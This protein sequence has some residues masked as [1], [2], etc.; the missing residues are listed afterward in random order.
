MGARRFSRTRWGIA[1]AGSVLLMVAACSSQGGS[2][3]DQGA[4][5][6]VIDS[7]GGSWGDAQ[8]HGLIEPFERQTG[9]KVT[10][11]PTQDLAKTKAAIKSGS[12]P[13]VDI[14]DGDFREVPGLV[15][16]GLLQ[17]INYAPWD[18]TTKSEVPAKFR[19]QYAI[20]WARTAFGMCWDSKTFP[21]SGPQPS[22]WADFWNT[23][24]FPGKRAMLAWD[25]D[26]FPE[27]PLLADGDSTA[28]LYPVNINQSLNE[29]TK[30]RPNVLTFPESLAA[31]QQ[32]LIDGNVSLIDCFS[33]RYQALVNSGLSRLRFSYDQAK[34]LDEAYFVWKGAPNSANAMKFLAFV[35][36]AKVQAQW[37]Q[38]SFAGPVNGT[39]LKFLPT[40][41]AKLLP[42]YP[43]NLSKMF[44]DDDQWYTEKS[45][46][47][48]QTNYDYIVSTAWPRWL[49]ST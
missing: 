5:S 34:E 30:L 6:L 39:A 25:V 15:S 19:Q 26:P 16:A 3:S 44:P 46:D 8:L 9:I 49:N 18:A 11:L 47:G 10:L 13:P 29:L 24:K 41:L 35:D 32:L 48:Q 28:Q 1:T 12:A 21:D 42:T 2:A 36:Q 43:A 40:D 23:T 14:S 7:F 27:G 4:G 17:P 37:A 31:T 22:G 45:P 38:F 20:G 33:H